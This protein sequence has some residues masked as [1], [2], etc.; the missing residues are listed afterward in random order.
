[1]T[2]LVPDPS[3]QIAEAALVYVPKDLSFDVTPLP[4][5]VEGILAFGTLQ[6][7]VDIANNRIIYVWGYAPYVSWKPA[8][9]NPPL[10]KRATLVVVGTQLQP[11]VARELW[12]PG[13][14]QG[15]VDV[16]TG[17]VCIGEPDTQGEAIE[18]ALDCI[19]VLKG[20]QL[21]TLWLH[22][23]ELPA[24]WKPGSTH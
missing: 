5:G 9:L 7:Q 4:K 14:K 2:R 23:K 19:A 8:V 13:S 22:P 24:N 15:Y 12:A 10:S 21:L 1:M 16:N 17:W 20:G 3:A 18:F 6:L 11:G